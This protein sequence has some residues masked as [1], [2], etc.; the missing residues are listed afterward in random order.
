MKRRHRTATIFLN[1]F[2]KMPGGSMEK[3]QSFNFFK[4]VSAFVLALLMLSQSFLLSKT[5]AQ[6]ENLKLQKLE[7]DLQTIGVLSENTNL[8]QSPLVYA[9][10]V[11]LNPEQE[12][13]DFSDAQ[14]RNAYLQKNKEQIARFKEKLRQDF[15]QTF[16]STTELA[17]FNLAFDIKMT[18]AELARLSQYEE[19]KAIEANYPMIE[20]PLRHQT[21]RLTLNRTRRSA[22]ASLPTYD[23][24]TLKGEGQLISIIDSG[25]DFEHISMRS[26]TAP[27]RAKYPT[28]ESVQT[29]KETAGIQYGEWKSVKYPFAYNYADRD[30]RVSEEGESHGSHVAAIAAAGDQSGYPGQAPEA[31]LLAMRVFSA[32]EGARGTEPM[33]YAKALE[34][35]LLLGAQSINLSL[36][37]SHAKIL[38]VTLSVTNAIYKARRAGVI[39][40][41]AQGNW[42]YANDEIKKSLKADNPFYE[43][44]G[45]PAIA[46]DVLA[47]ASLNDR[48]IMATAIE[49]SD[50]TKL[51]YAVGPESIAH[52]YTENLEVVDAGLGRVEDVEN[53]SLQGKAALIQR[54]EIFFSEKVRNVKAKGAVLALIYNSTAGGENFIGLD[55]QGETFPTVSMRLSDGL[56]LKEKIAQNITVRLTKEVGPINYIDANK[57]SSFSSWGP[58]PEF[59][60]KPEVTAVGGNVYAAQPLDDSNQAHNSQSG[61]SMATPQVSGVIVLLNERMGKDQDLVE[62][63]ENAR[64]DFFKNM[65][66]SNAVPHQQDGDPFSSPR[67]QGAGV[68]NK[69]HVLRSYAYA[70]AVPQSE[71]ATVFSKVGLGAVDQDVRF[72][73]RIQ[74]VSK[75]KTL[76][77]KPI[78]YVHTDKLD[79]ENPYLR[80]PIGVQKIM[81]PIEQD[82]VEVLPQ[83]YTDFEVAFTLPAEKVAELERQFV[84]GFFVEGF[85]RL[86]SQT[87]GQNDIGLPYVG[88]H[89]TMLEDGSGRGGFIDAMPV[90]KAIYEFESLEEEAQDLPTFYHFETKKANNFTAFVTQD[91][92]EK[93]QVL[94]ETTAYGV[95]E[96]GRRTFDR[97]K[98][99]F[100]PN[101]DRQFDA[102]RVQAVFL[103]H[104]DSAKIEV[105]NAQNEEIYESKAAYALNK[106]FYSSTA[107]HTAEN[108]TTFRRQWTWDGKDSQGQKVADGNYTVK[109]LVQGST[110]SA[111]WRSLSYPVKVDTQTPR[112]VSARY[113][114][115]EYT[116]QI[117]EQ[118]SGIR[119]LL[120]EKF[121]LEG[122]VVE[123]RSLALEA[124][125]SLRLPLA[126]EDLRKHKLI[127]QDFAGNKVSYPLESTLLGDRQGSFR[128]RF[129]NASGEE[130]TL[131]EKDYTL[132]IRDAEGQVMQNAQML[133]YG[134]YVAKVLPKANKFKM[135]T[136]DLAFVIGENEKQANQTFQ[137]EI[138]RVRTLHFPVIIKPEDAKLPKGYQPTLKFVSQETAY[139]VRSTYA[140][141]GSF[142]KMVYVELPSGVWQVE[143][144]DLPEGFRL[145][146]ERNFTLTLPNDESPAPSRNLT[147]YQGE[148]GSI[149][150]ELEAPE[151]FD[152]TQI[153]FEATNGLGTLRDLS[154]L[155]PD[156]Y[157]VQPQQVPEGYVIQP[158]SIEINLASGQTAR[159]HFILS[160]KQNTA[161]AQGSIRVR[162]NQEAVEQAD[163]VRFVAVHTETNERFENLEQ[164]PY[165]TYRIEATGA[166]LYGEASESI[167]TLTEE[168]AQAEVQINFTRLS[169]L[170]EQGTLYFLPEFHNEETEEAFLANHQSL[171]V[172]LKNL[173][174]LAKEPKEI[175]KEVGIDALLDG[176]TDV[177]YGYYALSLELPEGYHTDVP[178]IYAKVSKE[179]NFLTKPL[180]IHQGN[181]DR[182]DLRLQAGEVEVRLPYALGYKEADRLSLQVLDLPMEEVEVK[183]VAGQG[184]Y[185]NLTLWK[186][187]QLVEKQ[188]LP[189]DFEAELR[190]PYGNFDASKVKVYAVSM[191]AEGLV[192]EAKNLPFTQ[193]ENLLKLKVE[194]LGDFLVF[195]PKANTPDVPN[196]PDVSKTVLRDTVSG[197]EV[198]MA[199]IPANLNFKAVVLPS[200]AQ[201]IQVLDLYFENSVTGEKTEVTGLRRVILPKT[202]FLSKKVL[203]VDYIN[204]QGEKEPVTTWGQ[205]TEKVWLD[206]DHFSHYAFTLEASVK[207]VLPIF[208]PSEPINS[209]QTKEMQ[210]KLVLPLD[211]VPNTS[212]FFSKKVKKCP[213]VFTK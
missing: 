74:N 119:Y 105:Y 57:L 121:D 167:V 181:L 31:Q 148:L 207:P 150:P 108:L 39:V 95:T 65:M 33:Y 124:D 7:T 66:M 55:L 59:D 127:L 110:S 22:L 199:A 21:E 20:K 104:S 194:S 189:L 83:S 155:L 197:A 171:R 63:S 166:E 62:Q 5:F 100:S 89:G 82:I 68:M 11:H 27:E 86:L 205:D 184:H 180:V 42:G 209:Q 163:R 136:N 8:E 52:L 56:L 102:L 10:L 142:L 182:Q 114:Q 157:V 141:Y 143:L 19:V 61:T 122:H 173:D 87:E 112:L 9:V 67:K 154:Q 178:K 13:I 190:L 71:G 123:T 92:E 111:A 152:K 37:S 47:V 130:I 53:L 26:L 175:I 120:L 64:F 185:Y 202:I 50:N 125:H 156:R 159:P 169:T 12:D 48:Q 54:G 187:N 176:L 44:L 99:A 210:E 116:A 1:N 200:N 60:L 3:N 76:R 38:G 85:V 170:N 177:P 147:F 6:N 153:R 198:S 117:E 208:V 158:A 106:N 97:T 113:E 138:N 28:Q 70:T 145:F 101:D 35:S 213:L 72:S 162:F 201:N 212:A 168:Q 90:E 103:G 69:D 23:P 192:L 137:I 149:E 80:L 195:V 179:H 144:V 134:S 96:K 165:G 46:K 17:L 77:F 186:E 160:Q 29:A 4:K 91:D 109:F 164:L 131:P 204:A 36:G 118:G 183:G 2:L 18:G 45:N 139:E 79:P 94:G 206:L 40:N 132:Q 196:T 81:E 84:N 135:L 24:T 30:M 41:V 129:T 128:L 188:A 211:K 115:G 140:N 51:P 191:S 58:S 14:E 93:E 75:T 107:P 98:I 133:P 146:E 32:E 151:G 174:P 16:L 161:Q 73:V 126:E 25:F 43:T 193:E 203:S 15:S 88:Y 49:L 78:T 34:D 172:K